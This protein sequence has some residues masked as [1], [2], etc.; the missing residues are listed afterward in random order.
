MSDPRA[1]VLAVDGGNSKTDLA[2]VTRSGALL[3]LVS[4]PTISH[5]QVPIETGMERLRGF[6]G[7]ARRSAGVTGPIQIGSFCLAGADFPR[8]VRLLRDAIG[9]QAVAN[10]IEVRNDALAALRAGSPSGWG[11]VVICG[12]GV[13]AVGVGPDGRAARLAGIGDLSGDWGGGYGVGQEALAAAVRARDGRGSPTSLATIVPRALGKRRPI[14]V[15]RAMYDEKM[16]LRR[17]EELAPLVF[18]AAADGDA[19]ARAIVDRLADEL[20]VMAVAIA[21]RLRVASR[22][23][24]VV[25]TGGVFRTEEPGFYARLE[26]RLR[27]ALPHA[28][29]RRLT[30]RPVLG[31][32]LLG[33]DG[34]GIARGGTVEH[35]LRS[36]FG[37]T[38]AG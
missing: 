22:D 34:L 1:A 6:V 27:A 13:N 35:R 26:E 16:S 37:A 8:D 31:A 20:A 28:R 36:A 15:T 9:A 5:Q 32:A 14:D 4:G 19:V 2:L 23:V 3:A 24:D 18:A 17:L 7:R 21:R 11:V 38:A 12:A 33:L 30:E 29:T 25:L 10:R